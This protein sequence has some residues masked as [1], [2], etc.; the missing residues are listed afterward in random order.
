MR[1][2]KTEVA[3]IGSGFTAVLGAIR[4]I[5]KN[6]GVVLINPAPEF[7]LS[8]LRPQTGLGLWNAAYR[9]ESNLSLSDLYDKLEAR[10]KEIFPAALENIELNRCEH[11]SV[12]SSTPIHRRVTEDL[13][14]EFFK[15]ERKPWSAGQFRLVNPDTAIARARKLDLE[16]DLVARIGGAIVKNYGITWNSVR[17]GFYL[18]Q[19]IHEKMKPFIGAKILGRYGRKLVVRTKEKEEVSIE[20]DNVV[21]IFLSGELLPHVKTIVSSCKEPWIQGV[22]KRRREQHFSWFE[23]QRLTQPSD[24]IWVELGDVR[25]LWSHQSGSASWSAPKGPDG[26]ERVVDEALRLRSKPHADTR[27]V[28]S[29]RT[30]RLDWDWKA[31]QWKPTAHQTYW[32]TGYEGDLW[33][34]TELLWNM[35]H[36]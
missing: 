3:I 31:P 27:F 13:E 19:F 26:L 5:N 35:P 1:R 14:R 32:A 2:I 16:L 34:V 6:Q 30:F 25:Y 36:Q 24:P 10:L 18:S 9:D 12:L 23:R 29:Q 33:N 22:R 11:W 4:L 7:E 28:R 8:D 17:M 15:L 20:S 21:L